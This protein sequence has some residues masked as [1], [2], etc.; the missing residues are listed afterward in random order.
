MC[1]WDKF[2]GYRWCYL[3]KVRPEFADRCD[4]EKLSSYNWCS[5]LKVRPEFAAM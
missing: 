1:D 3:L 2:D 5:L 4:W